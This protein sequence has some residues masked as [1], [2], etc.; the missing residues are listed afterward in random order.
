M[1][2]CMRFHSRVCGVAAAVL[3]LALP[4]CADVPQKVAVGEKVP[5]FT[6]RDL[7]GRK[8]DLK[9]LRGEVVLLN[10]WATWCFPCRREMP[11][12]EGLHREWSGNGLRVV[13]VSIDAASAE[14]D[15]QEFVAE[16]G[17]TFDIVH[18]AAQDVTRAFRT[19]GVPETF[20]ID[21][22]GT[23]RRHWIGRIDPH[24]ESVRGP[25]RDVMREFAAVAAS[26]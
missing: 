22:D 7:D 18:D 4:A 1:A 16:Y 3:L 13:A 8:V 15:I 5:A 14:R 10:V 26:R 25:I 19:I 23:L 21:P 20:L 11:A 12:L 2:T 17:L 6:G 9:A 24:S